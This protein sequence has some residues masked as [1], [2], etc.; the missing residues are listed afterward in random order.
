MASY[1][2]C[3][4]LSV[5]IEN[6]K[7]IRSGSDTR[8]Y[9]EQFQLAPEYEDRWITIVY[10]MDGNYKT[11]HLIAATKEVFRMWD[12]TLRKLHAIRQELMSGLGNIEMRQT[13]W[14]KQYWKGKDEE[15]DQKLAFD[16]V[17][18][19]CKRLNINSSSGDLLRIFKVS[20]QSLSTNCL[21]LSNCANFSKQIRTNETTLTLKIFVGLSSCSK[22]DPR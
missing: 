2:Q 12:T 22:V 16:D 13:I 9:R 1:K 11:L 18:K 6:I 7:E 3:S 14:E 17:E 4:A 15:Q 5:P 8:Y 21:F 10:I 20:C 19:L